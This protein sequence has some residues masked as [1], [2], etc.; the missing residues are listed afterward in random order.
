MLELINYWMLCDLCLKGRQNV[1][2]KH[3]FAAY[4]CWRPSS[5]TPQGPALLVKNSLKFNLKVPLPFFEFRV[6]CYVSEFDI[7]VVSSKTHKIPMFSIS[8]AAFINV[9]STWLRS[10]YIYIYI[11]KDFRQLTRMNRETGEQ[12][13]CEWEWTIRICMNE[14]I[15]KEHNRLLKLV[16]F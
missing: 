9:S 4:I 15:G 8:S 16:R 1:Q 11:C 3:I 5:R 6:L 14:G 7:Y 10:I 13:R 2:V 12:S